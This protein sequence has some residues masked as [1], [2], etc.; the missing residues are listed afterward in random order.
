[1]FEELWKIRQRILSEGDTAR[2]DAQHLL[3]LALVHVGRFAEAE[4]HL[5]ASYRDARSAKDFPRYWPQAYALRLV[6][7]YAEWGKSAEE[8]EWVTKWRSD[9]SY[10]DGR[11]ELQFTIAVRMLKA[12]RF[13]AAEHLIRDCLALRE[14]TQP[15]AWTT[16]HTKSLLGGALLGQ[17]KYTDAEPLLLAGYE[18]MKQREATIPQPDGKVRLPEA[19]DRL[20]ELYTAID[21]P[22]EV[23][24]WRAERARYPSPASSRTEKH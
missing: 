13:R 5:L 14:K 10:L 11:A 15:D 24:K 20:I 1:L 4:P 16:F 17:K 23:K 3:G 19:L 7:L 2:I 21:K 12:A 8:A 22:D 18:G 6:A 9:P